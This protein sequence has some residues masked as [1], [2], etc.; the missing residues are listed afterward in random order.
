MIALAYASWPRR[1]VSP[2]PAASPCRP[3]GQ[4]C[5]L[6]PSPETGDAGLLEYS[7]TSPFVVPGAGPCR[8]NSAGDPTQVGKG[9]QRPARPPG[10]ERSWLRARSSSVRNAVCADAALASHLAARRARPPHRGRGGWLPRGRAAPPV[11]R[12]AQRPA[13]VRKQQQPDRHARAEAPPTAGFSL[14]QETATGG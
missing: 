8:R 10:R 1:G 2:P 11:T 9:G 4:P 6:S 12:R 7:R 14:R 5:P 13:P 3:S